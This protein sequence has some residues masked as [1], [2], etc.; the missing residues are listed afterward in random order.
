MSIPQEAKEVKLISSIFSAHKILMQDVIK[1]VEGH[2]GS[3]D[4]VSELFVF[5]RTRYYEREMGWPLYRRFL[6]FSSLIK[7]D[8]LVEI[9]LIT[10]SI[11][12]GHLM[13]KGRGVNID[14]GYISLERLV[15]ATG[16][17]YIHRIY[18]GKGIYAD[19]TLVFHAGTFTPLVWTYPDYAH[20]K[21]IA[22]F[23]MVRDNYRQQV[24]EKGI[25]KR[26]RDNY[27]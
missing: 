3:V 24:T 22:C 10:N 18:L 12:K 25:S 1:E 4:W 9:K 16:K 27:A 2:F 17:N 11:E 5:D 6:S 21:V 20:E 14:P 23:N 13:G 19:L 7:P 26:K 8:S 15:L